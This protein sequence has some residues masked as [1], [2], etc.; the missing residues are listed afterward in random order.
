M[1]CLNNKEL[2]GGCQRRCTVAWLTT[3]IRTLVVTASKGSEEK[4]AAIWEDAGHI[5]LSSMWGD[6]RYENSKNS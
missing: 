6:S 5:I 1:S 4:I 3:V 2:K